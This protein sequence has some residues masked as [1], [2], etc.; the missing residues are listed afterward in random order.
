M[1]DVVSRLRLA[2][3]GSG[4]LLARLGTDHTIAFLKIP[5]PSKPNG[6]FACALLFAK[7]LTE[8]SHLRYQASYDCSVTLT[9]RKFMAEGH[10][11]NGSTSA[12]ALSHPLATAT[13]NTHMASSEPPPI[14]NMRIQRCE[15]ACPVQLPTRFEDHTRKQ[16]SS[17]KIQNHAAHVCR[18]LRP[19]GSPSCCSQSQETDN[20]TDCPCIRGLLFNKSIAASFDV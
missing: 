20:H 13:G 3:H 8:L 6:A 12:R 7:G 9:E 11:T 19:A 15:K 10:N 17:K 4:S 1:F 5:I 14:A 18:C 16:T 2:I